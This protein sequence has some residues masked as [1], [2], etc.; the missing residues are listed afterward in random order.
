MVG[1]AAGGP[2]ADATAAK[3]PGG[4]TAMTGAD[5]A[6]LVS[7]M[8]MDGGAP[9]AAQAAA[10]CGGSIPG[11][12]TMSSVSK[13]GAALSPRPASAISTAACSVADAPI[14]IAKASQ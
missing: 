3:P 8:G 11:T 5:A 7:V 12:A 2:A 1:G 4:S 10:G 14:A 9:R 6:I 13:G